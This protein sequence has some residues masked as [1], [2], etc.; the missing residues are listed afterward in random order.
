MTVEEF[1]TR[2]HAVVDVFIA[3]LLFMKAELQRQIEGLVEEAGKAK[4]PDHLCL[5]SIG[6]ALA[7]VQALES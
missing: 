2:I 7:K 6:A 5:A 3:D 1:D 4:L